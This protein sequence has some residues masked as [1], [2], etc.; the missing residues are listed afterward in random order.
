MLH[1]EPSPSCTPTNY[2]TYI[3]TRKNGNLLQY[4]RSCSQ[5]LHR[6][7]FDSYN[8]ICT[9]NNYFRSN[10]RNI[11]DARKV[12]ECANIKI[13]KIELI[14]YHVLKMSKIRFPK[15]SLINISKRIILEIIYKTSEICIHVNCSIYFILTGR[16]ISLSKKVTSQLFLDVDILV[17]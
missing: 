12:D 6:V 16:L 3:Q 5:Y 2:N 17:C 14:N 15:Q 10:L 8:I 1:K 9:A 11:C 13:N 4:Q 7:S